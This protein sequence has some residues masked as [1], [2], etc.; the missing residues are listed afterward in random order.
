V[1]DLTND[2][3]VGNSVGAWN[4]VAST[5]D[6]ELEPN[7]LFSVIT[8]NDSYIVQGGLG[9]G[10]STTFLKNTTTIYNTTNKSWSKFN[11]INETMMTPR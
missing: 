4:N 11:G 2:F 9:Y 5:S 6:F 7:S 3:S 10:S 1:F 8:L